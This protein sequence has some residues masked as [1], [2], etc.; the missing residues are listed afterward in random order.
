LG[1][2]ANPR[3]AEEPRPRSRPQHDQGYFKDHGIEPA[4]ERGTKRPWKLIAP[5]AKVIG[6]GLLKCRERLGGVLKFYYR[7][8][9]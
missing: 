2:H 3:C 5:Q 7:E 8:A 6:T 4:P 1:L 9:A